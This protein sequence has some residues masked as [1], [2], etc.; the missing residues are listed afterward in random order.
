MLDKITASDLRIQ[1]ANEQRAGEYAEYE[2]E[3]FR[4]LE[5]GIVQQAEDFDTEGNR[6]KMARAAAADVN[7][8]FGN[9]RSQENRALSRM[10]VNPNSGRFSALNRS[11]TLGQ[12]GASAGAMTQARD[13]AEQLGFARKMDAAS[14]GRNL[15]S[16]SSG[17]Y[18]ISLAAGQQARVGAQAGTNLMGQGYASSGQQLSGAAN[19][20]GTA[21][22][23][24]GSEYNARMQGYNANQ[25][26]TGAMYSGIGQIAG[27]GVG[28]YAQ[29]LGA[30]K[31]L[32]GADGGVVRKQA[33]RAADGVH[34]GRGA[35]RGPGGPVDDKVPALLSDGEYVLP[36]DTTKAIGKA[37]LDKLV[38]Q[39]HTPAAVQRARKKRK[40]IKG[41]K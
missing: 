23:I 4:P 8:S 17:A 19:S 32:T 26:A 12:A 20:Y 21:G 10:G 41:R 15:A 30:A 9:A 6:E 39:T 36:S 5:K 34:V 35:V 24:Y 28:G 16:N 22:N 29:G 31:G 38:A 1:E 40:A 2:R 13:N 18:G 37:K 25:A 14:L 11:L 3:T 27:M 7:T 33:I